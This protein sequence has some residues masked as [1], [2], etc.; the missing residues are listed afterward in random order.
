MS[1]EGKMSGMLYRMHLCDDLGKDKSRGHRNF[2][3]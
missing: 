2:V 1:K 3:A